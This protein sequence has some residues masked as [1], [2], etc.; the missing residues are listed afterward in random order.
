ME[1]H[2]E[3]PG[4]AIASMV[5]GIVAFFVPF[6][7][8]VL[9]VLAIIFGVRAKTMIRESEGKLGGEGMAL[10][11]LICGIVAGIVD[12]ATSLFWIFVIRTLLS[13]FVDLP[14]RYYW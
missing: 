6:L 3:I 4:V 5:C 13:I 1:S 11:G 8:F 7:G 2:R 12:L 14:F 10:T 9:A